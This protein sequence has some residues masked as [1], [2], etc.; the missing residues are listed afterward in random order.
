MPRLL[1]VFGDSPRTR[2]SLETQVRRGLDAADKHVVDE[3][4]GRCETADIK[5]RSVAYFATTL[6]RTAAAY[7]ITL[8]EMREESH[9]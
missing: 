2:R 5:P 6:E 7:G 4:I 9:G 1:V 8:V 3:A